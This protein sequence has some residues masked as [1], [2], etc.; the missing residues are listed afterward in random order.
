[1]TARVLGNYS[2]A[3]LQLNAT[4]ARASGCGSLRL[5]QGNGLLSPRGIIPD[6]G[7]LTSGQVDPSSGISFVFECTTN[8][9]D[10][11]TPADSKNDVLA[12]TNA[13]PFTTALTPSNR[14]QVLLAVAEV[15]AADTFQGGFFTT[16][17]PLPQIQNA[18]LEVYWLGD[19][20]I[21]N[22]AFGGQGYRSLD[23]HLTA[24]ITA[25]ATN[26]GY[27]T[28]ISISSNSV[29]P[30]PY[31][32]TF[33]SWAT[34]AGQGSISMTSDADG[35]GLTALLEYAYGAAVPGSISRTLLPANSTTNSGGTNYLVLNYFARTSGVTV[36]PEVN[37]TLATNGWGTNGISSTVVGTVTTNN[38]TLQQ[39]R[40]TVPVDGT[41]KFLRLKATSP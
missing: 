26:G 20:S 16:Q 37:T 32:A 39:R 18:T 41:R 5:I 19:G 23:T 17:N 21:T 25:V 1:M 31:D 9:P 11:T 40:A 12:L 4:N 34:A 30:S 14:V 27:V 15:A 8:V 36:M 24:Q 33:D 13:T 6:Q 3:V 38:T 29:M 28:M 2:Q 35:N 10:W 22:I 7:I